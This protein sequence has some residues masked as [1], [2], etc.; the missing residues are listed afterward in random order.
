MKAFAVRPAPYNDTVPLIDIPDWDFHWQG[1]Y[2]FRNPIYLP[3]GTMLHGEATYDNTAD[4]EDNPNDPPQYVFLGEATTDEMMLFYFAYTFGFA[5]DTNIVIDDSEHPDHYQNC[6]TDFNIGISEATIGS[7]VRISPVPADDRITLSI[8]R[9]GTVELL[10]AQGRSVM[11]ERIAQGDNV[12]D[13][14][15]IAAGGYAVLV[16][17]GRGVV[18]HRSPLVVK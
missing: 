6:T 7:V 10:D 17:D 18:L 14:S 11:T 4:N 2:D 15:R 1:L 8:D 9:P 12:L 5:T 16:R 3:I 13:L